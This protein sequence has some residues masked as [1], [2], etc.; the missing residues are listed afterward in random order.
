MNERI[1]KVAEKIDGMYQAEI[2]SLKAE[3]AAEREKHR[4]MP[5]PEPPEVE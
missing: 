5:M 4:W 1:L 3:L 2:A